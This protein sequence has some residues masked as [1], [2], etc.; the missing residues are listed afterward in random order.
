MELYEVFFIGKFGRVLGVLRVCEFCEC[1]EFREFCGLYEV[2][3]IGRFS[4]WVEVRG[5]QNR[6]L[7]T[8][9]CDLRR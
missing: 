9:C 8:L 1:C 3:F 4:E 6:D 2:F 7:A 5:E